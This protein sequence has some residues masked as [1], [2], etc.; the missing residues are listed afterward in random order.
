MTRVSAIGI[1]VGIV[2]GSATC[3]CTGGGDTIVAPTPTAA[4]E[5]CP[6][7]IAGRSA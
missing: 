5:D 1:C 7:G 2:L 6:P 4:R 3:A